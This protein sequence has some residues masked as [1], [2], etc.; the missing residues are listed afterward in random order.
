MHETAPTPARSDAAPAG[1]L[2]GLTPRALVLA[3]A[4]IAIGSLWVMK[5]SLISH[6]C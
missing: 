1:P 3:S 5:V 2:P 4:L 6:T